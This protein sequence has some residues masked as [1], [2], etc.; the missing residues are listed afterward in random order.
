M[1]PSH[2]E[3]RRILGNY[4]DEMIHANA[5]QVILEKTMLPAELHWVLASFELSRPR[6]ITRSV[7]EALNTKDALA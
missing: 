2:A 4:P 3:V 1:T 7:V 5:A 6:V